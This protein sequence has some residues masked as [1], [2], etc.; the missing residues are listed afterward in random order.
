MCDIGLFKN[1]LTVKEII[2][3]RMLLPLFYVKQ[4]YMTVLHD[5][6]ELHKTFS[7]IYIKTVIFK[8]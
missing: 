4:V 3:W 5:N 6:I 7:V 8:E 2:A 1:T